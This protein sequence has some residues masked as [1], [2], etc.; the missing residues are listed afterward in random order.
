MDDYIFYMFR[1][2]QA[3]QARMISGLNESINLTV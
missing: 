2:Y 1:L 3:T